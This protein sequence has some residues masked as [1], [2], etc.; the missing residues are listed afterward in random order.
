MIP[1]GNTRFSALRS[2]EILGTLDLGA[3]QPNLARELLKEDRFRA[4]VTKSPIIHYLAPNGTKFPFSDLRMR[5]AVSL[6]INRQ[7]IADEFY[8][9]YPAPAAHILNYASPFYQ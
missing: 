1:D 7:L 3:I 8:A 4:S 2:E 6:I 5:Q 9:G